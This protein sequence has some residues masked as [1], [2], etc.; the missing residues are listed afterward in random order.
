MGAS[1]ASICKG[2]KYIVETFEPKKIETYEEIGEAL[3][4][5]NGL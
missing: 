4:E 1:K 2:E 5:G 3:T